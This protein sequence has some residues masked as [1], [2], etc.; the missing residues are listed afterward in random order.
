M[1][2]TSSGSQTAAVEDPDR[3]VQ[4]ESNAAADHDRSRIGQQR[5]DAGK[6]AATGFRRVLVR[7]RGASPA[8]DQWIRLMLVAV[9]AMLG[10]GFLFVASDLF[11]PITIAAIAY[12]TLR[13]IASKLC[14]MGLPQVLSSGLVIAGIF[15]TLGVVVGML[16]TPTQK[17]I[18]SAPESLV[19]VRDN[20]K[21][22]AAPLTALD[23]ADETL[24]QATDPVDPSSAEL[25]V[26]VEKPS[27]VSESALI[28]QTGELLA[29]VA[30]IAVLT[31]FM[32]STG[33]D[34]LNRVLGLL[35]DEATRERVLQKIG[36]IQH[37]VGKYLGQ[38]TCINIGLGVVVTLVMWLLDMPT[39]VLWGVIATLFNFIPYVGALAAT[40]I[41]F[42]AAASTFDTIGRAV[43]I[44]AAFWLTTAVEGQFVTPSILGK[45]LRVGPVVVL[46]AVAFWGFLWGIAGVFLAVPLLIIQRKVFAS[47]DATY[48]MAVVLGEDP[49]R[50][51]DND[52]EPVKEDKPIAETA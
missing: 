21:S 22:L 15:I 5:I 47:F 28:N 49:C 18:A 45:T 9:V 52:C 8:A 4:I 33:D 14:R 48:A 32:L 27:M 10:F 29:F 42:L 43:L 39:P 25:T 36:D 30:A 38:I 37:S 34:L 11:I 17:W 51:G 24:D 20:F 3:S 46:V 44:A 26:S 40:A 19:K 7:D 35:P 1:D 12:L 50:P 41:V 23:R 2:S 31:F 16:Y 13:P 6:T